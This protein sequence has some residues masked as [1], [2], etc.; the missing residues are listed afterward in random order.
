ELAAGLPGL[1]LGQADARDLRLA[2]GAAGDLALVE[3]VH[4]EA[5]DGL[6]DDD[7]LVLG[8]VRQHRRAG[9]VADRPQAG[10]VG[11]AVVIDDD[12]ATVDLHA[13]LFEPEVLRVALHADGRDQ[14][15]AGDVDLA[16]VLELDMGHDAGLRF[17]DLGDLGLGH[18]LDTALFEALLYVRG[19]FGVLDRQDLRQQ[20]DDRHLRAERAV[21]RGE[22]HADGPRAHD[23]ERFRHRLGRHR[24]EIGP[25]AIA[26]GL[27]AGQHARPGAGRDDDVFGLV[28]ARAERILGRRH[29]RL[30]GGLFGR[31]DLDLAGAGQ[32]RLAPDGV[33]LVLLHEEL[34]AVVHLRRDLPRALDGG[35]EVDAEL[36]GGEAIVLGVRH[37]A[38]DL[39]RAQQRLG[40]NAPPV[41]EDAGHVLALDDRRP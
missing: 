4:L 15:I 16:A 31:L 5:G 26:V 30:H 38:V 3:A 9:D 18:E 10:N 13:E 19:D 33:D 22:L 7:A 21:E 17:V 1:R 23:D 32:H 29:L 24:L 36:F 8:L 20:L 28:G 37:V 40:R 25:D 6:D 14:G 11:A 2:I 41:G 35:V 39:G 12:G 34:D 27:D